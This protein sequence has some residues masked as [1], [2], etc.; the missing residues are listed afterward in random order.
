[1]IQARIRCRDCNLGFVL[2]GF[3]ETYSQA[4]D[5]LFADSGDAVM[6]AI[7]LDV[8][9]DKLHA[10]RAGCWHHRASGHSY[11]TAWMP[12]RSLVPGEDPCE[13]NMLDDIT[14]EPLT[15]KGLGLDGHQELV[16]RGQEV[17]E[18]SM[19]YGNRV[20]RVLAMEHRMKYGRLCRAS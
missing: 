10:R 12:P 20:R 16:Q 2:D 14:G 18:I 6:A 7:I 3:P 19:H 15:A 17:A 11:H 8:D 1:M 4:S 9:A 5:A 13:A